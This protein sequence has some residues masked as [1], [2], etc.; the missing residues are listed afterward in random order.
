[1]NRTIAAASALCL[2]LLA[3]A[4]STPVPPVAPAPTVTVTASSAT[5]SAAQSVEAA[6]CDYGVFTTGLSYSTL[7]RWDLVKASRGASDHTR[8]INGFIEDLQSSTADEQAGCKGSVESAK[9]TLALTVLKA[10]VNTS[11]EG[12]DAD[13]TAVMDAGNAWLDALGI[14]DGRFT[15][16]EQDAKV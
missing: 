14:T 9:L 13:Y 16:G 5:P 1:M 3:T 8:M 7:S 11:D 12:D 2:A 6:V 4:C 10:K 15:S